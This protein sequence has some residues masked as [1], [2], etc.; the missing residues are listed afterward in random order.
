MWSLDRT[1]QYSIKP[2]VSSDQTVTRAHNL[3]TKFSK[4]SQM[5]SYSSP[6]D[7]MK[8][9]TAVQ[10]CRHVSCFPFKTEF[11]WSYKIISLATIA[12]YRKK[13]FNYGFW[14]TFFA[15][16]AWDA[17]LLNCIEK[18]KAC[19]PAHVRGYPYCIYFF[20][21]MW[22]LIISYVVVRVAYMSL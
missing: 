18:L 16:V 19:A 2:V 7:T 21:E 9:K 13:I 1:Y 6:E 4:K 3:C 10:H 22:S 12:W 15:W 11:S 5:H 17:V 8:L 20:E 14:L